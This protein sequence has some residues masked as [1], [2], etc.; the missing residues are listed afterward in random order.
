M[1]EVPDLRERHE[2][3]AV[4]RT[5][6]TLKLVD[7]KFEIACE[8]HVMVRLKRI[9]PKAD[10]FR[11][12][13]LELRA[14]TETAADIRWVLDRWPLNV[15][16]DTLAA[17]HSKATEYDR[18][19]ATVLEILEGRVPRLDLAETA[20][21]LRSYQDE[22]SAMVHTTGRLLLIDDVGL[23][24]TGAAFGVLRHPDAL[25]ALIVT[26][27]H[28]PR[29]IVSE[30]GRFLPGLYGH[31]VKKGTPYDIRRDGADPDVIVMNYSKL[32]GWADHLTGKVKTVIFD[33]MQ[34]LRR[35]GSAKYTAAAMVADQA[36]FRMGLTATPVYNY[37]GEI[38][39]VLDVLDHGCLGDRDEFNR[40][41]ATGSGSKVRVSDPVALGSTLRE[42]G[43]VLRRT[44]KDVGR[45]LPPIQ[46]IAYPV[47][48][49]QDAFAANAQGAADL[50]R[51]IIA[52]AGTPTELF[53]AAGDFD[54]RLRL[55]TGVAKAPHVADFARLLLET[56]QP[57]ILFGW[58]HEV[59][60]IWRDRLA[61]H[62]PRFFTGQ[63][64]EK[65]KYDAQSAF[66]AGDT[67]LLI[68]SLRAGA[69]IDGLQE[70]CSVC[71]FGELDWSPGV[72]TQCV[73][74]LARDGQ[75]DPVVAYF[76][77]AD[78]GSDP[79]IAEVLD[80]KRQQADGIVD[81]QRP[82]FQELAG[83]PED[84][85][86]LLAEAYLKAQSK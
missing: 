55:A 21:P 65:Q 51:V 28:L 9:F 67:N 82:L 17:L 27:T 57:L 45:E 14:T 73:G 75:P 53:K 71:V 58:H 54:W 38:F 40:E 64:S 7:D 19:K 49:D 8:P 13:T 36:R 6:G 66:I 63:E 24:K 61:D 41:W 44:R 52:K 30:L 25:P 56:E 74:R 11:T 43:L 70:R 62:R 1:V 4:T 42:N 15:D 29:Q 34:E 78:E 60:D 86:K 26:L 84:R 48:I 32:A 72:H 33:E 23:G 16:D 77:V 18:A 83:Q 2:G 81:P 47:A 22:A 50:A 76:A 39:N 69:G 68:M 3:P 35:D 59:Y 12:G 10:R 46:R 31:V 85:I 79:V 37:G 80:L 20:L 5:Y